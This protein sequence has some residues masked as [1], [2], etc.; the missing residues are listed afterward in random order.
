M[1]RSAAVSPGFP[2]PV[3]PRPTRNLCALPVAARPVPKRRSPTRSA[4]RADGA[5]GLPPG[6]RQRPR[7]GG[8]F[9]GDVPG[10]RPARQAVA[11][12][13]A[14]WLYA[15]AVRT[16]RG[17]R[18]MRDRRRK[19]DSRRAPSVS[20]GHCAPDH[21]SPRSS[22]RNSPS[23]PLLPRSDR[24]VRTPRLVAPQAAAGTRHSRRHALQPP[25]RPRSGSWPHGSR[26]AGSR[27]RRRWAAR[28]AGCGL[29]RAGPVGGVGASAGQS[30]RRQSRAP[31]PAW[32]EG[33]ALRPT[34]GGRTGGGCCSPWSAADGR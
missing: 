6:A 9:P 14:G 29:G 26:R 5:G 28:R 7:R 19:H 24:A 13:L 18:V 25:R 12:N 31:R 20:R 30:G 10:A 4:A 34:E 27:P 21:D 17:V 1:P 33:N 23:S 32:C 22:T 16:A 11:G 3:R 8:R 15:V 2:A